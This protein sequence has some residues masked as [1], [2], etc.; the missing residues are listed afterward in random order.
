MILSSYPTRDERSTVNLEY[1]TVDDLSNV[2]IFQL[3]AKLGLHKATIRP[4]GPLHVDVFPRRL[5][6]KILPGRS[7]V[8][9]NIPE[10]LKDFWAAH[11]DQYLYNTSARVIIVC[12]HQA[13]KHYTKFL[14]KNRIRHDIL[15]VTRIHRATTEL[16]AAW[17]ELDDDG[18]IRRIALGT[19]APEGFIRTRVRH[20]ISSH[21]HAAFRE[22]L[23]DFA[24]TILFGAPHLP[25]FLSFANYYWSLASGLIIPIQVFLDLT[26]E[27][28]TLSP[29]LHRPTSNF[30]TM[31][32]MI[33]G[34]PALLAKKDLIY[35]IRKTQNVKPMAAP[36]FWDSPA[37]HA[38]YGPFTQLYRA[39]VERFSNTNQA[40]HDRD[41][42]RITQLPV[43][44][45]ES[46]RVNTN[47]LANKRKKRYKAAE[48]Q[49][50]D[51]IAVND[52]DE[53]SEEDV[54][55]ITASTA[56][57]LSVKRTTRAPRAV[58]ESDEEAS[59][60]DTAP[61]HRF[62]RATHASRV[63]IVISDDE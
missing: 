10:V 33:R 46:R 31:D 40:A 8:M 22:R 38:E 9:V 42:A 6:R 43:A 44:E 7:G 49:A 25:A 3:Y 63:V 1:G 34:N 51:E 24:V 54:E 32:D 39:M 60:V 13:R 52:R 5:D 27:N 12:G 48:Q 61:V 41:R 28:D 59:T 56:P 16:L 35:R 17:V 11:A 37:M 29:W 23:M 58:L 19:L 15:W 45:Q 30:S 2:S 62:K 20:P 57:M 21:E 47:A 55:A 53:H 36:L 18:S 4:T 14:S 26:E 50:A